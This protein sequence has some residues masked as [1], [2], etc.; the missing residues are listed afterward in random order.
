MASD[1]VYESIM[2]ILVTDYAGMTYTSPLVRVESSA[3]RWYVLRDWERSDWT[4]DVLRPN[5]P[6]VFR[7]G[8]LDNAQNGHYSPFGR[9]WQVF[10]FNLLALSY[11]GRVTMTQDEYRYLGGKFRGVYGAETGFAN[12][13]GFGMV[14]NPRVD[15][16]NGQDLGA[17]EPKVYTLVCGGA[18]LSGLVAVNSKGAQMLKVDHFDVT[19]SPPPIETFH[20]EEDS[21]VFFAT[22]IT[23]VKV[24]G[25]YKVNRFPQL[26]GKDVPVPL[27]ASRDIYFPLAD[28]RAVSGLKP[29]PYNP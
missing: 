23:D 26:N 2:S 17:P 14:D 19:Q 28:V 21:R 25:G 13:E 3:S 24:D 16:V 1:A 20:W 6:C 9:A 8:E 11:Y 29:S 18:T 4:G 12:H 7:C 27:I 5:L 10:A 22:T 15:Y